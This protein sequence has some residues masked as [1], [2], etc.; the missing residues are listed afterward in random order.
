MA[1]TPTTFVDRSVQYPGRR[2]SVPVSGQVNVVDITRPDGIE[3]TVFTT[4]TKPDAT[5]LNAEFTKIKNETDAISASLGWNLIGSSTGTD[6]ITKDFTLYKELRIITKVYI[7]ASLVLH[8]ENDFLVSPLPTAL[9]ATQLTGGYVSTAYNSAIQARIRKSSYN[10]Y[11]A[12][13]DNVERVSTC[14]TEIYAK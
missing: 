3:G 9:T 6:V 14:T 10:L 11:S 1:Y 12:L 5:N 7:G 4:G 2:M 13:V 8:Q